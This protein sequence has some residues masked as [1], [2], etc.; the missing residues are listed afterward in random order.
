MS[1]VSLSVPPKFTEHQNSQLELPLWRTRDPNLHAQGIY[2]YSMDGASL[3]QLLKSA[4]LPRLE[5]PR[6]IFELSDKFLS[7]HAETKDGALHLS[8]QSPLASSSG[9]GPSTI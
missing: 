9:M 8:A 5:S 3:E 2:E 6:L 7:V 4:S 1:M